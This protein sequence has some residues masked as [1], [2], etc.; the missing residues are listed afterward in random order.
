M[1]LHSIWKKFCGIVIVVWINFFLRILQHKMLVF[2]QIEEIYIEE[3]D[4]ILC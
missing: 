4:T 3:D 1:C 2:V